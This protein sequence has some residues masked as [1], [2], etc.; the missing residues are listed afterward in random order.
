MKMLGLQAQPN[1]RIKAFFRKGEAIARETGFLRP[2]VRR[3]QRFWEKF[4]RMGLS[5]RIIEI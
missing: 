1:L 4:D 5:A 3:G 2:Q